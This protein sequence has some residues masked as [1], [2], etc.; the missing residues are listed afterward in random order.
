MVNFC[1]NFNL[2]KYVSMIGTNSLFIYIFRYKV[3]CLMRPIANKI[4]AMTEMDIS[5]VMIPLMVV[6]SISVCNL[7]VRPIN[8]FAPIMIGNKKLNL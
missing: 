7:L 8:K 2:G 4:M 5:I 1:L 3:L 6:I